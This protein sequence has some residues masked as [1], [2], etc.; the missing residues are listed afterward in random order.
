MPEVETTT[1][2]YTYNGLCRLTAPDHDS[3]EFFQYTYDAVGNRLLQQT[4]KQPNT[5]DITT[6]NLRRRRHLHLGRYALRFAPGA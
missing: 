3:G 5:Y 6:S 2:D 4:L 1:I